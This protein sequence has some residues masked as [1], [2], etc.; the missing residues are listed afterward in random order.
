MNAVEGN[1]EESGM[2]MADYGSSYEMQEEVFLI[3][4][5]MVVDNR[6]KIWQQPTFTNNIVH[7]HVVTS[8]INPKLN[9]Q[10]ESHIND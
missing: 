5:I 10:F 7:H 1:F 2:L 6:R 3:F 4:F 8:I 9:A